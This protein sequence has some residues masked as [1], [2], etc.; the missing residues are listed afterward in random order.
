MLVL[1]GCDNYDQPPIPQPPVSDP[2]VTE[3][4]SNKNN[5]TLGSYGVRSSIREKTTYSGSNINAEQ[6]ITNGE[7]DISLG[8]LTLLNGVPQTDITSG[9]ILPKISL[10]PNETASLP[11]EINP[12]CGQNGDTLRMDILSVFNP[13]FVPEEGKFVFGNY[14]NAMAGSPIKVNFEADS[15][16]KPITVFEEHTVRNPTDS[17]NSRYDLVNGTVSIFRLIQNDNDN[18]LVFDNGKVRFNLTAYSAHSETFRISLYK[19]HIPVKINNCD[20]A[21]IKLSKGRVTELTINLDDVKPGDFIYAIAVPLENDMIT[22]TKTTSMKVMDNNFSMPEESSH[23]VQENVNQNSSQ[24]FLNADET[25]DYFCELIDENKMRIIQKNHDSEVTASSEPMEMG[26]I[27]EFNISDNIRFI[28]TN[29]NDSSTVITFLDKEL[30]NP[31]QIDLQK[32]DINRMSLRLQRFDIW[33]N[34]LLFKNSDGNLCIYDFNTQRTNVMPKNDSINSTE[35]SIVGMRFLNEEKVAYVTQTH[36]PIGYYIGILDLSDNTVV[37]KPLNSISTTF[38]T[39]EGVACWYAKRKDKNEVSDGI[40]HLYYDNDFH[41]IECEN[42]NENQNVYLSNDGKYVA[43]Y[44]VSEPNLIVS[45]YDSRSGQQIFK[46]QLDIDE[47]YNP[48]STKLCVSFDRVYIYTNSGTE[49]FE[50]F[51]LEN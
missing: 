2:F 28:K 22:A 39:A 1:S 20:V 4:A 23:D 32:L 5:I 40:I 51:D 49:L 48:Y 6:I 45:V 46:K 7:K 12:N 47:N 18:Y 42:K 33:E 25:S 31:H 35:L 17:E 36:Q 8:F 13:D 21:D 14:Q 27:S 30:K 37:Q 34:K 26:M 10:K 9:S 15:Q 50:V 19:N 43:T 16:G 3:K 24:I 29:I 41:Q 38:D 11:I 44:D